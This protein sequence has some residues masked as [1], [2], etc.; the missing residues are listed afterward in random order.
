MTAVIANA[1]LHWTV[2]I[3]P[4][5]VIVSMAIDDNNNDMT[6]IFCNLFVNEGLGIRWN[7]AALLF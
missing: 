1:P 7:S 5:K 2:S 3:L 4:W 6:I